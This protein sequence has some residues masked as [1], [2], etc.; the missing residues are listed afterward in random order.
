MF[1]RALFIEDVSYAGGLQA[2]SLKADIK[3][4]TMSA[5]YNGT[6]TPRYIS[7]AGIAVAL[8]YLPERYLV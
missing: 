5:W 6:R 2:V 1:N 3:L 8:G 7:L 4:L